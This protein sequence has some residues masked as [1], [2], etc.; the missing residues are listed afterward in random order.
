MGCTCDEERNKP[1]N[2]KLDNKNN[3]KNSNNHEYCETTIS[4][5]KANSFSPSCNTNNNNK[6]NTKNFDIDKI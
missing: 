5:K 3:D 4:F 2:K 6:N 1:K